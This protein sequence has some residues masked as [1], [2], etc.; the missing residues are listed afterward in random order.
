MLVFISAEVTEVTMSSIAV[1]SFLLTITC[2]LLI[3]RGESP[4]LA[5]RAAEHWVPIGSITIPGGAARHRTDLP[6]SRLR[7]TA[8]RLLAKDTPLRITRISVAY[9]N[10]QMHFD[11]RAIELAPGKPSIMID[12]RD[13]GRIIDSI[14][15]DLQTAPGTPIMV[16]LQG[17]AELTAPPRAVAA[18]EVATSAPRGSGDVLATPKRKYVELGIFY[19][20]NRRQEE[21]RQKNGRSLA[22]F[23][24]EIGRDLVLGRAIVTIPIER[25]RG[26]IPRPETNLLFTRIAFR[27]EDPDRDFTLAA[28]DVL[29][30]AELDRQ[31]SS[32][33]ARASRF[34]EQAL[35]FVHGYNVGFDDSIFRTAQIAYDL[36]F[37]GPVATFSWPSRGGTWDYRHDLDTAKA[38]RYALKELLQ[39]VANAPGIKSVNLIAHSLGNDPVLEMLSQSAEIRRNGGTLPD[40]K[41]NELVLAAPDVSR[42]V[43][44]QFASRFKG[45]ARGGVTLYASR[46]DRALQA[47]RTIARG[48]TRAGDVPSNG[49][50]MVPGIDSIDIS[51]ASTN[52]FSTNHSA[53]ADR[54]HMIE[55][56]RLLFARSMR[57]PHERFAVYRAEGRS[58]NRWWRYRKN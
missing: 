14:T 3:L 19:G 36:G 54:E 13:E 56:M 50:V 1:R 10:G 16:E 49:I 29:S 58:P 2:C 35:V 12:A 32:Q 28:I 40:F 24:G 37:D 27:R 11:E 52:F 22:T 7:V 42:T 48:L 34:R 5:Q 41:L 38:S 51:D 4:A 9:A 6:E 55:D 57:P 47:S 46:N 20:T 30:A 44:E 21:N 18:K 17:K 26:S 43:F 25:E 53:F 15:L 45:M 23:S 8:I 33:A 31:I 39:A